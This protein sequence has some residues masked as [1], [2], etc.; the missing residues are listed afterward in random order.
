MP[1]LKK[2]KLPRSANLN[3][4][5]EFLEPNKFKEIKNTN[6]LK[7]P[8]GLNT[9]TTKKTL[10]A[11]VRQFVASGLSMK[12]CVFYGD[13]REEESACRKLHKVLCEYEEKLLNSEYGGQLP[14]PLPQTQLH[15]LKR[16]SIKTYILLQKKDGTYPKKPHNCGSGVLYIG[17]ISPLIKQT[18]VKKI[19][20][21]SKLSKLISNTKM[22]A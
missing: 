19:T 5:K 9:S 8:K 4:D 22:S 13:N 6:H 10:I 11:M 16:K 20:Y 2:P 7:I 14:R 15:L 3:V 21:K 12:D 18:L 17:D 1:V